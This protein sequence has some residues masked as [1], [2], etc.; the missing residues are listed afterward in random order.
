MVRGSGWC[1]C[2]R[3]HDVRRVHDARTDASRA[4]A[5]ADAARRAV[6]ESDNVYVARWLLYGG[7][8]NDSVSDEPL[9]GTWPL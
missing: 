3:E 5:R 6:S 7:D 1:V 9:A 4:N 8:G 2:W